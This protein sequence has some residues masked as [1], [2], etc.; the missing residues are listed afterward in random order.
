MCYTGV[1][2]NRNVC[3]YCK[4]D[5]RSVT[6]LEKHV[7]SIL[8]GFPQNKFCYL[9]YLTHQLEVEFFLKI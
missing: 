3:L 2:V 1:V 5:F 9:L 8:M 7:I 6:E 4:V